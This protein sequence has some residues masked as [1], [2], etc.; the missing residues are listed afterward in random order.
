LVQAKV[1]ASAESC[2][3]QRTSA[4]QAVVV[5]G[6]GPPDVLKLVTDY[7]KPTRGPKQVTAAII[8]PELRE[9]NVK[10]PKL[11]GIQWHATAQLMRQA[12]AQASLV[13]HYVLSCAGVDQG[14]VQLSEPC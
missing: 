14:C 9:Q 1:I 6:T 3:A 8:D 10:P 5:D 11:F 13:V 2:Q 7:L 12:H 4:M